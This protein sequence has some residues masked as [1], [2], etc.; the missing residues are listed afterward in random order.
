MKVL[1]I[2]AS[3]MLARPVINQLDKAGF[4]LR[5]FSRTVNQAMFS[6]KYEIIQGDVFKP[7]DLEN[8]MDGSDTVHISLSDVN[9]ALAVRAIVKSAQEKGTKL[10]SYISGCTVA[11]Q[12]R[13]FKVIENKYLAE[14]TIIRS[15]IPYMI[16]RPTWFFESLGYMVRNGK[17]MMLGKQPNPWHWVA[18]GD[19][20]RMVATAYQKPEARNHI[21]YIHGPESLLM[22]DALEEYCLKMH[23]SIRRV[24]SVPIGLIKVI[25]IL[26]GNKQLRDTAS[27][28][29]YFE[30][31][32]E[33]GNPEETNN[34]LGKPGTTLVTWLNTLAVNASVNT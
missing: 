32:K 29:A 5:L 1:V 34:I 21:F 19:F 22:K 23:P 28:F 18:A 20:A 4:D 33:M 2:G 27:L 16:F 8:A 12:N 11:E 30:K 26:S 9:E 24:S 14:Q 25:A 15:G 7:T 17:A 3:G 10:I 6:K 13:R 31:A